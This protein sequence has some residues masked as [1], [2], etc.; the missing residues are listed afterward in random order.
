MN[1]Q[2]ILILSVAIVVCTITTITLWFAL[3]VQSLH[4]PAAVL[5]HTVPVAI[6][7][8]T[9]LLMDIYLTKR[10]LD[11]E[12]KRQEGVRNEKKTMYK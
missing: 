10:K 7:V 9:G 5:V 11:K 12:F 4:D 6:G 1:R 8:T 2:L 3:D